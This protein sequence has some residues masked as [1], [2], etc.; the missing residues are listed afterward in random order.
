MC[1]VTDR[2]F[3]YCKFG[4]LNRCFCCQ[5]E[6]SDREARHKPLTVGKLNASLTSWTLVIVTAVEEERDIRIADCYSKAT[7]GRGMRNMDLWYWKSMI[8]LNQTTPNAFEELLGQQS[9]RCS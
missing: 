9:C 7:M 6:Q 3:D 2:V 5:V 1:K 8:S 4:S